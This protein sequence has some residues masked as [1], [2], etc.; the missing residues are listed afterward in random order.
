MFLARV[1]SQ[2]QCDSRHQLR[3]PAAGA[4]SGEARKK[5]PEAGGRPSASF[6]PPDG[7]RCKND[8][9]AVST[10]STGSLIEYPLRWRGLPLRWTTINEAWEPPHRFVDTQLKGPY[11]L[12]LNLFLT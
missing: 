9:A 1:R 11:R 12:R 10:M 6:S 7:L 4:M 2:Q 8:S 3:A 5:R